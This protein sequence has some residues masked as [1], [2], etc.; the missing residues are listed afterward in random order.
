MIPLP[1]L[2]IIVLATAKVEL[3]KK[4]VSEKAFSPPLCRPPPF[5]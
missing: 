1:N 5:C 3:E 2:V 4:V